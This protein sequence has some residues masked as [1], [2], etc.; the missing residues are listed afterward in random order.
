MRWQ[1]FA[2]VAIALY[3]IAC[4]NSPTGLE[5]RPQRGAIATVVQAATLQGGITRVNV[6]VSPGDVDQDLAYDETARSYTG[7]LV[8]PAGSVTVTATAYSGATPV[9][10]ASATVEVAA[11]ATTG[12]TLKILDSTGAP[13]RPDHGPYVRSLVVSKTSVATNEAI[14]VTAVATDPDDDAVS[15]AWT[16]DCGGVFADEAAASTSWSRATTGACQLTVTA[17][18]KGLEDSATAL[19]TVLNP[20]QLEVDL[21]YVTQPVVTSVTVA[22]AGGTCVINRTD[23]DASCRIPITAGQ[24][25]TVSFTVNHGDIETYE[26]TD[27]CGGKTSG[28]AGTYTWTAPTLAGVCALTAGARHDALSDSFPVAI[29]VV[30][31][32][33]YVKVAAGYSHTVAVKADGTL[34]AWGH[35]DPNTSRL[36]PLHYV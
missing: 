23:S 29:E 28:A 11:N 13:P 14:T 34:W 9:G 5:Q 6:T 10:T 8:A 1:Y 22:T 31:G 25:A 19:V 27:D 15:Y 7:T 33:A 17:S 18:S 30:Q 4:G 36:D 24:S 16:D 35:N 12:V 3:A 32:T 2:G 21:T 26:L 20:T